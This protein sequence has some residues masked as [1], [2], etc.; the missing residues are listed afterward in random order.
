MQQPLTGTELS[1]DAHKQVTSIIAYVPNLAEKKIRP[2]D[3]SNLSKPF[4]IKIYRSSLLA[5]LTPASISSSGQ[6]RAGDVPVKWYSHFSGSAMVRIAFSVPHV[7][8]SC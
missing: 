7:R 6:H 8:S 5:L 4:S 1:N 3:A 2:Y